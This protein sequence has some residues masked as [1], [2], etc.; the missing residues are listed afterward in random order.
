MS[1]LQAPALAYGFVAVGLLWTFLVGVLL[2]FDVLRLFGGPGRNLRFEFV[3]LMLFWLVPAPFA[4]LPGFSGSNVLG[5]SPIL[6]LVAFSG[7]LIAIAVL[8]L[9]ADLISSREPPGEAR[10]VS[11]RPI[12]AAALPLLFFVPVW[13]GVFGVTQDSA[14]GVLLETPPIEVESAWLGSLAINLEVR[15]HWD[16]NASQ[17]IVRLVWRFHGTFEAPNGTLQAQIVDSFR[18]RMDHPF[19]DTTALVLVGDAVNESSW[20]VIESDIHSAEK[21]WSGGREY[22]G[23]TN[24]FFLRMGSRLRW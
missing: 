8:L 11:W 5:P 14:Q 2:S 24:A 12:V 21:V 13:V 7:V 20:I 19:Y 22:P 16:A 23:A 3:M 15:L 9:Y 6:Y 4:F 1:T 18:N 10:G 17:Y